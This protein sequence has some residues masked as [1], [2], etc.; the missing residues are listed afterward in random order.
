LRRYLRINLKLKVVNS[1]DEGEN[2]FLSLYLILMKLQ[3]IIEIIDNK[4]T[5]NLKYLNLFLWKSVINLIDKTI[6]K[7]NIEIIRKIFKFGL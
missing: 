1:G 6:D 3:T 5:L 4:L 7:V 2:E